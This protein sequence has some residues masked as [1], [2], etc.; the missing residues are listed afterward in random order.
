MGA[1]LAEREPLRLVVAD[2][3]STD[4]SCEVLR[5]RF[6]DN[7]R[8]QILENP[9]NLGF[10]R[11]VNAV[12][13]RDSE[14]WLL[15]LNPDC[16][17]Q[18]GA[19]GRLRQALEDDPQAALAAPLVVGGDGRV[20][21]G[22][23]RTFPDP[24]RAFSTAT[25]LASLAGR[26]GVFPGVDR[27]QGPIPDSTVPAEAVSG[28]CMMVRGR[29]FDELGGF[30]TGFEMHFEDLDLMYRIRQRG[31]HCLLVPKALATHEQG[32]SSR[33]RRWW[34]HRQKHRG[35]QRFFDKHGLGGAGPVSRGLLRA[36]IWTH[37]V[38]T[39]PRVWARR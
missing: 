3:D 5:S 35:M 23:L 36:A 26:F 18:A 19:L 37:Y 7:E 24:G 39:L 14:E 1:V 33:S 8:L 27:S 32:T 25:G 15:I 34:V 20:Q 17:L 16:V 6:R 13:R 21:R 38:L 12:S 9:Q 22:T 4:G 10:G 2:N 30:D 11:A 29:A 31:W 28:A